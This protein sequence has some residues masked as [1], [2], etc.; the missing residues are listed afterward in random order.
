[1]S[2]CIF[3]FHHENYDELAKLVLPNWQEYTTRHG[4]GLLIHRGSYHNP[5]WSIGFQRIKRL[6]DAMFVEPNNYDYF[7][8]IGLDVLFM[9][10]NTRLESFLD[11][12]HDFFCHEFFHEF[13]VDSFLIKKS[14]WSE[15]WL[16]F[17]YENEPNYRNDCWYEQRVM[18]HHKDN[19]LFKDGIKVLPHPGINGLLFDLYQ[20]PD[21]TEGQF[22][23][24]DAVL[25]LPGLTL[26]HRLSLIPSARIQDMIVR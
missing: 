20:R 26:Q 19:P 22:R 6:Y 24:G 17:I 16:R 4:Y 7:H 1:M 11:Q 2:I 18:I 15:R 25:H 12:G 23:R 9:N 8:F 10:M 14:E 5:N 3:S 13:N 21:T